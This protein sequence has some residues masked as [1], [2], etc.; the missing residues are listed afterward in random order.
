MGFFHS[1]F[2]KKEH[3]TPDP[4]CDPMVVYA[5]V[6]GQAYPLQ[7]FPD[8][9]FS[10]EA[11]GPGCGI[12]PTGDVV[13]APFNG[14]VTQVIDTLHAVTVVSETGVTVLIHIGVDT[15]SMNGKGFQAHVKNNQKVRL[16]QPLI[17]FDRAA[18]QAA[19]L[20]DA[21]AVVVT[22]GDDYQEV[23]LSVNGDVTTGTPLLRLK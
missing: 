22:N 16:G 7:D 3:F 12:T 1:L 20:S 5:P 19:G 9:L 21:I 13:V 8:P 4:S 18:I 17:T 14:T 2:Q 23:T 15:V 6:A 10:Q 11:L